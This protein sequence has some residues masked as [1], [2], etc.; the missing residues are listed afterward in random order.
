[1]FI[2]THSHLY[3]ENFKDDIDI[4]V[5]NAINSNVQKIFLPN[6]DKE[7]IEDMLLLE[8][9]YPH[10]FHSMLGLHPGSVKSDFID[11]ID[12]LKSYFDTNKFIAIGEVGIDLY[13]DKSFKNEQIEAF[14]IQIDL[15]IDNNLPIVI[16]TRESMDLTIDILKN[17]NN[18]KIKGIFHCFIGD[19]NQARKVIE[20][21]FMMGIGG[22]VTYKNS[23]LPPVIEHFPIDYMVLETDSPFLPPTPYR[24]KRNESSYIPIIANKI[25]ELKNIDIKIIENT[26]TKNAL[27]LFSLNEL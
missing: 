4:V 24:G 14:E 2:D 23:I 27:E 16:H 18:D 17:R 15:A 5:S 9:R 6:I 20:L 12:L 3:L 26:T 19:I 13:W 25:A 7:S 8:S 21:G 10:I 22:V 11:E 1:M